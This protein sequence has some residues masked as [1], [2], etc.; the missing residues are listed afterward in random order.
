MLL[1]SVHV[2]PRLLYAEGA[3]PGAHGSRGAATLGVFTARPYWRVAH[4][5]R[6][7]AQSLP[8]PP[9]LVLPRCTFAALIHVWRVVARQRWQLRRLRITRVLGAWKRTR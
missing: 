5:I 7:A 8:A 6:V 9:D 4:L 3:G 1:L 2:R